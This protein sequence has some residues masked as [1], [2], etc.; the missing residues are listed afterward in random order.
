ML[1]DTSVKSEYSIN[2]LQ[3]CKS[4]PECVI[5]LSSIQR[6]V[7]ASA[8]LTFPWSSGVQILINSFLFRKYFPG[9][10]DKDFL[11][12]VYPIA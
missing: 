10:D 11:W 3:K 5:Y 1:F 12:N 2:S 8:V 7:S 9:H 4:V 6:I